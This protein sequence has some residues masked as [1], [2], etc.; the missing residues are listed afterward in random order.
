MD[1]K[2]LDKL[3]GEEVRKHL[4][5]PKGPDYSKL[6]TVVTLLVF[7]MGVGYYFMKER[8]LIAP[9]IN[10]SNNCLL[11]FGSLRVAAETNFINCNY[12]GYSNDRIRLFI[13]GNSLI[14]ITKI[15]VNEC[16]TAFNKSLRRDNLTQFEVKCL[17]VKPLNDIALEYMNLESGLIHIVK[18]NLIIVDSRK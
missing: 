1:E 11:N 4:V 15:T 8:V 16:I 9:G 12:G 3:L 5:H 18:G 2:K 14:R 10:E 7:M 17:D 6:L 13:S